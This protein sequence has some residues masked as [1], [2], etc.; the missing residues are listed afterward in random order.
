MAVESEGAL[1]EEEV[2]E[3]EW[4]FGEAGFRTGLA[5]DG[6]VGAGGE[7]GKAHRSLKDPSESYRAS[8][9]DAGHES[10]RLERKSGLL[11]I[12]G[13]TSTIWHFGIFSEYCSRS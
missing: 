9:V 5:W 3:T 12:L 1:A 13:Y 7:E 8:S 6:C 10:M 4:L 2:V 11:N